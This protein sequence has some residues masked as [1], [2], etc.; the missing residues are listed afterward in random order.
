MIIFD[1]DTVS[2]RFFDDLMIIYPDFDTHI[3]HLKILQERYKKSNL[4]INFNKSDFA[5]QKLKIFYHYLSQKE[6]Q[7]TK[8]FQ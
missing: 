4:R 7:W 8:L 2:I 1:I 5:Q 6:F 3:I